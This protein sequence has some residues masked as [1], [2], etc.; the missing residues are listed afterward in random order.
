MSEI[1][2]PLVPDEMTWEKDVNYVFL[3]ESFL[4]KKKH[5]YQYYVISHNDV[6]CPVYED[7][8]NLRIKIGKILTEEFNKYHGE[9]MPEWYWNNIIHCWLHEFK[10]GRAHV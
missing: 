7:I 5:N 6:T 1:Y 3:D 10:I 8:V 9:N 4:T 2:I